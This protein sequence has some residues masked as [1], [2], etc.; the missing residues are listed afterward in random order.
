MTLLLGEARY[1]LEL[2]RLVADTDLWRSR[3]VSDA[4]PVLLVPGFM[5]G[6]VSMLTLGAWLRR[7]GH[8][9]SMSGIRAN[10]DCAEREV[11]R[12]QARLR[13]LATGDSPVFVI[14]QSRGG[15]LARVLAAREPELVCGLV[16]LGAPVLDP[17]AVSAPVLRALRAVAWLGDVGVPGMLSN[18]CA[19]GS[20]C[21]AFRTD[22]TASLP[23][24]V[25]AVAI[26]SRSD[27]IVDWRSCLDP[28]A[29]RIEVNSS[30]VGMA[31]N[32]EVYRLLERVVLATPKWRSP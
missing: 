13:S 15:S 22:L 25:R 18:K 31:V 16:T 8:R 29:E 9:V 21:A 32:T 14:G 12:L 7:R 23:P 6:D 17:L 1:G 28:D 30:H 5:A 2:T 27:G 3:R 10:V 24:G 19:G 26:H 4:P 11:T 20:C